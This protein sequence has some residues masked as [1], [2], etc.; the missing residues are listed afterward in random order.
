MHESQ[1]SSKSTFDFSGI[2]NY[3]PSSSQ[4]VLDFSGIISYKPPAIPSS[5][6][7]REFLKRMLSI[8]AGAAGVTGIGAVLNKLAEKIPAPPVQYDPKK[9]FASS[10]ESPQQTQPPQEKKANPVQ[11][12][13]EPKP[14]PKPEQKP[15][16]TPEQEIGNRNIVEYFL[17][18]LVDEFKK[19]RV[20]RA[21]R[22]PKA[23]ERVDSELVKSDRINVLCLGLDLERSRYKD[24]NTR[25]IGRADSM[26][27][28]SFD[29]HTF[30]TVV[31]SFP[32]DLFSPEL[33]KQGFSGP[34]TKIN[35]ITS[36]IN[37]KDSE[38]FA[39]S[40]IESATGLPVDG[41]V[42]INIDFIQGFDNKNNGI[43][44]LMFPEGLRINV[45]RRI[46]DTE[47]PVGY[48]VETVVFESGEQAMNSKKLV[49]Y[50]RSRHTD[51]DY[52]RSER[53][54]QIVSTALKTFMKNL[55]I[56]ME[57]GK[58]DQLDRVV[59]GLV[60][61]EEWSNL[62]GGSVKVSEIIKPMRDGL[63]KILEG[64]YGKRI[65]AVLLKNSLGEITD[66]ITDR[67]N[68]LISFGLSPETGTITGVGEDETHYTSYLTK[69]AGS[70]TNAPPTSRGNFLTYWNPVREKVKA[71]LIQQ[72]T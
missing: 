58:T 25:G 71:L 59:S 32:R 39:R 51:S 28:L 26:I 64:G 34:A 3:E 15:E 10:E 24:F 27:L 17:G 65:L 61:H 38:E 30:K 16:P 53:Q 48:G 69:V 14:Q 56:D 67:K 63:K 57:N 62:L 7:R 37:A 22:N 6:S 35:A 13:Q 41:V 43:F 66:L 36:V 45:P 70:E 2:K 46:V 60:K 11:R 55:M 33:A 29:P 1:A 12:P 20:E 72:K 18:N 8:T 19:K 44:D 47:Y 50:G 52:G 23:V 54:R 21:Y 68:S 49:R 5:P 42:K 40:V 9:V 4:T 31:I